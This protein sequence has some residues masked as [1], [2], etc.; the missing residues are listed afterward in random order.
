[1]GAVK[2]RRKKQDLGQLE[3]GTEGLRSSSEAEEEVG[4][5]HLMYEKAGP[6]GT[7]CLAVGH[8]G[9]RGVMEQKWEFHRGGGRLRHRR[10]MSLVI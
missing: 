2:E 4:Q 3:G 6:K 9:T 8:P 5:G 7:S 1:M 10:L